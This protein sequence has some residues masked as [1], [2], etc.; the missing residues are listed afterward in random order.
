MTIVYR[1]VLHASTVLLRHPT[2]MILLVPSAPFLC[3]LLILGLPSTTHSSLV[4]NGKTVLA[5]FTST[6]GNF[7]TVTRLLLQKIPAENGKMS[8][9][10][11]KHVFHYIVE[12]GITYLC[13]ADS[14]E[15]RIPFAFL[16][17]IKNRFKYSYGDQGRTAIAFQMNEDFGRELQKQMEYYNANPAAD[18]INR[19]RQQLDEVK[20]VMVQNIEK[21]LERGEK[22][23]LLVDKTDKLNQQAFKFEKQS[24]QLKNA[25]WWRNLKMK[26]MFAVI[27]IFILYIICG[28]ACG[29]GFQCAKSSS[30]GSDSTT[31]TT[32]APTTTGARLRLRL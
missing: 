6:S 28:L 32:Q 13:M 15:R 17:D 18:N 16:E 27:V 31:T 4:A 26:L 5:E 9:V 2:S 25:M 7:P 3:T 22:I 19:V 30:S 24:K 8:Y 14:Q 20:G 1:C 10:Y 12:E 29:F 21:V 11:D 23:E